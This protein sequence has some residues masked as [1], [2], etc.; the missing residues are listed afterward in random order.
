MTSCTGYSLK[1]FADIATLLNDGLHKKPK[2]GLNTVR[3]KYSHD[4]FHE[5][6]KIPLVETEKLFESAAIVSADDQK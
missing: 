6:A 4:V 1:E 2:E 3:N 5:V